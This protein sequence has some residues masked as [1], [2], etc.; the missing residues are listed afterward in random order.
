MNLILFMNS[1]YFND[2]SVNDSVQ[3][4]PVSSLYLVG[5][6]KIRQ[7]SRSRTCG[8]FSQGSAAGRGRQRKT[9]QKRSLSRL[10][11]VSRV[12]RQTR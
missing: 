7:K 12:A 3:L 2:L 6:F 1:N 5:V 11:V 4:G 10:S 8:C 9:A